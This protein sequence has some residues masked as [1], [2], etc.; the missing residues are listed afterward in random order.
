MD[1][2]LIFDLD[3]TLVDTLPDIAAAMNAALAERR[4][5]PL[6]REAYRSRVGWGSF[7]LSRLSLPEDRRT[8]EEIRLLERS[9]RMLYQAA[10]AVRSVPFPGIPAL[11]ATLR[12]RG[13]PLSVLT[14]K[15]DEAVS[16]LLAAL[17][18]GTRFFRALGADDRRPRK[19]DPAAALEIARD[20]GLAPDRVFFVGDSAV[21]IRTARNAG[22]VPIG[23]AWGYRDISELEAEGARSIARTPE[24]LLAILSEP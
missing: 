21:D 23:V 20:L 17:F 15:P 3:G 8:D 10:P 9:F 2:A 7:E 11:L 6:P 12:S 14:N 4:C 13:I 16:P 1:R 22:M 5:P 19:P 18:P 24:D